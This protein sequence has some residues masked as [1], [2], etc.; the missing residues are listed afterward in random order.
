[1]APTFYTWLDSPLDPILLLATDRALTGLYL[2]PPEELSLGILPGALEQPQAELL[3]AA[4]AQ[5]REYFT[6]RRTTFDL[7]LDG[8]KAT[9]FRRTVWAGLQTIPYGATV[10]YGELARR[11]GKPGAARA[12]GLANGSN[13]ISIMVPCHR[14]IGADGTLTGYGGGLWRKEALLAFEAQVLRS[15]P[16]ELKPRGRRHPTDH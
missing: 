15:G 4:A 9:P 2:G 3:S 8:E 16:C 1:M 11:I 6:G 7:P 10:S 13:P 12:V 14:V 5:L